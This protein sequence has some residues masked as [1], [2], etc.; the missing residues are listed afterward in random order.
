MERLTHSF[1]GI[2]LPASKGEPTFA[3][4][5]STTS[6]LGSLRTRDSLDR[7]AKIL[8]RTRRQ[9]EP[10]PARLRA[11]GSTSGSS[12]NALTTR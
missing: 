2:P 10:K 8:P 5:S 9:S 11:G 1:M 7:M 4:Q 3:P 12:A 6:S